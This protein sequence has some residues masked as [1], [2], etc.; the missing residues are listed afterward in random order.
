MPGRSRSVQKAR[1]HL[2][3][4][5]TLSCVGFSLAVIYSLLGAPDVALV[6]VLLLTVFFD[7]TKLGE[8]ASHSLSALFY[9]NN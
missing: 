8:N 6:A 9:V 4:V 7:L 5:L 2:R 1:G 3:I